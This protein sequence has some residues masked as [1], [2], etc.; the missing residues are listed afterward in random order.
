MTQNHYSIILLLSQVAGALPMMHWASLFLFSLLYVPLLSYLSCVTLID[1]PTCAGFFQRYLPVKMKFFLPTVTKRL[2]TGVLSVTLV[3]L[4]GPYLW[5]I[6]TFHLPKTITSLL[7]NLLALSL[8]VHLLLN[9]CLRVHM[10][11]PL[12]Y[13]HNAILWETLNIVVFT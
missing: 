5:Y 3:A 9:E 13:S 11:P 8:K 6:S 1:A 2:L 4:R 10:P 12:W 7:D